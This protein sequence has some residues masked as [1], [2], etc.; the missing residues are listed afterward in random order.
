MINIQAQMKELFG[1]SCNAYCYAYLAHPSSSIKQL[2]NC[3]LKGWNEG[4]I[5]NDG[6][7]SKPVQ[8]YNSMSTTQIRDVVKVAIRRLD[9][10]PEG[11]WIVEY[12]VRPD[13]KESHFVVASR[14]AVVFDPAGDSNTV[15][16]GAPVSYRKLIYKEAA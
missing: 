3:V 2:T 11:L 7:V 12:K 4:N 5:D 6:F 16:Y 10:L 14:S 9:E 15:R 1:N 8:Y 13:F